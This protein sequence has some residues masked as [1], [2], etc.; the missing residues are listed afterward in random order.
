MG[1]FPVINNKCSLLFAFFS[2][3][4][5]NVQYFG[6][7]LLLRRSPIALGIVFLK[8]NECI[9]LFAIRSSKLI[10]VH[11]IFAIP[12]A[13]RTLNSCPGRHLRRSRDALGRFLSR[14]WAPKPRPRAL[15]R[16]PSS[17]Q[18]ARDGLRA[19]SYELAVR[20]IRVTSYKLRATNCELRVTGYGLRAVPREIIPETGSRGAAIR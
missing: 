5:M 15:K 2:S 19:T 17:Q 12:N 16:P 18:A 13:S 4:L 14:S 20:G 9:L 3:N 7:L 6:A 8:L 11:C 1:N 10:N